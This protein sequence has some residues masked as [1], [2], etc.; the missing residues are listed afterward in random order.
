MKQYYRNRATSSCEEGWRFEE[1][2]KLSSGCRCWGKWNEGQQGA[3]K[4]DELPAAAAAP[5][6]TNSRAQCSGKRFCLT[7]RHNKQGSSLGRDR[8]NSDTRPHT[9]T[10][11]TSASTPEWREYILQLPTIIVHG[12]SIQWTTEI[13]TDSQ[14][15]I[16]INRCWDYM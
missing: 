13:A 1:V 14:N 10:P 8:G 15:D 16:I 9:P 7:R 4:E 12:F 6:R 5:R 11:F 2:M 3:E